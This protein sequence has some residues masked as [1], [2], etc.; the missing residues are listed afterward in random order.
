MLTGF[1][2]HFITGL[3]SALPV[4]N[5]VTLPALWHKASKK[6]LIGLFGLILLSTSWFFGA[7]K[8]LTKIYSQF[9]GNTETV[10]ANSRQQTNGVALSLPSNH[11]LQ[12]I[13]SAST[14]SIET[15]FID[16]DD[17]EL[18][19]KKALYVMRFESVPVNK[20]DTLIHRIVKVTTKDANFEG[21]IISVSPSSVVLQSGGALTFE[22][23]VPK[24]NIRTLKLMVKK[25]N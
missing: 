21:Q 6:F 7:D 5:I 18:L 17:M 16:E 19:P 10:I 2:H 9:K 8:G 23:E 25:K 15:S 24:A 1:K 12:N 14:P 4:L 20:I 11:S 3:I 13:D 22:Q